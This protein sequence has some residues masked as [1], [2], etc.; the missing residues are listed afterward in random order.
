MILLICTPWFNHVLSSYFD[1]ILT[2]AQALIWFSFCLNL[3][4]N[5]SLL[6]N[7]VLSNKIK[8]LKAQVQTLQNQSKID[9]EFID[10][11][12]VC[13]FH[14]ESIL[15]FESVLLY[16]SMY[17]SGMNPCFVRRHVQFLILLVFIL[18]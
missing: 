2:I 12:L 17:H 11:L 18:L 14:K 4:Y 16:T 10:A 1:L 13:P 3:F 15:N 9:D 7:K 5:I 6:R 8:D